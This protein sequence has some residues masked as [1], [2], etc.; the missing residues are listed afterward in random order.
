[1]KR[2]KPTPKKNSPSFTGGIDK[3]PSE[4]L[5]IFEK[6]LEDNLNAKGDP[7]WKTIEHEGGPL[8]YTCHFANGSNRITVVHKEVQYQA[9]IY[10]MRF[11]LAQRSMGQDYGTK[12]QAVHLCDSHSETT[13]PC[14]NPEHLTGGSAKENQSRDNCMGWIWIHPYEGHEGGYWYPTCI[15]DPPCLHFTPKETVSTLL[16]K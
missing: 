13:N 12:T 4:V 11:A 16:Y 2:A 9:T 1:M 8:K 5:D 14:C 10:R 7:Y 3:F 15:H 6:K